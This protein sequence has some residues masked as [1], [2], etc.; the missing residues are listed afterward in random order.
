VKDPV[1]ARGDRPLCILDIAL[2]RD[3]EEAVGGLDNVFLYDLDDLRAAAA[4]N[5]ERR[6]ENVP[7]AQQIIADEAQKY[8]NWVAG[9]AAVPVVREFREEMD[10]VRSTELAAALR[11]LGPLSADQAEAIEHFSKALMN[12]FLHEPSVR[13]RAAAANGRGLGVVDAARYL[14]ALED[15]PPAGTSSAPEED[16]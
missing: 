2:P 11:R 9:L 4:A 14:F 7:A 12:K 6:E 3:V 10:R 5:V 8:W 16:E 15:K 1:I 13:L